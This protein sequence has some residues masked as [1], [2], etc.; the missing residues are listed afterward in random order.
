MD[1]QLIDQA[2]EIGLR[3]AGK[4]L[5][6]F[7][8]YPTEDDTDDFGFHAE[9]WRAAWMELRRQGADGDIYEACFEAWRVGFMGTR[10]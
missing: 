2:E 4:Y 10:A 7:G 8:R 5:Q 9:A 1:D 6:K 3:D